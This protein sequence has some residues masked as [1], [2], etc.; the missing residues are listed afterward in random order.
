MKRRILIYVV[1]AFAILF[2]AAL[3]WHHQKE[4]N[5]AYE[6]GRLIV[7]IERVFFITTQLTFLE[8]DD[9]AKLKSLLEGELTHTLNSAAALMKSGATIHAIAL[10]NLE[11]GLERA[12]TYATKHDL[13][14]RVS[15]NANFVLTSMRSQLYDR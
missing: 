13:N 7:E 15:S 2:A 6:E 4:M 8:Q 3:W 9:H 1:I 14:Q 11:N 5:R 12:A 10:P